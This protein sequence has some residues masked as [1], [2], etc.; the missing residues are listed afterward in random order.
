MYLGNL[1]ECSEH[2]RVV[3]LIRGERPIYTIH[4]CQQAVVDKMDAPP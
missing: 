2:F 1:R 4:V 3:L